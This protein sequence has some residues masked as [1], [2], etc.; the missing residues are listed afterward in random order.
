MLSFRSNE[1]RL[2]LDDDR[3]LDHSFAANKGVSTWFARDDA[4]AGHLVHRE[5]LTY[6]KILQHDFVGTPGIVMALEGQGKG[7]PTLGMNHVGS[8]ISIDADTNLL[9]VFDRFFANTVHARVI[10]A[11]V[12]TMP[13]RSIADRLL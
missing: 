4:D 7:D 6:A 9:S 5:F 12:P 11:G 1:F 8:V 13:N 3:A 10:R 2:S